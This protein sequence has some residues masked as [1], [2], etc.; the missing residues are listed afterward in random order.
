MDLDKI[1]AD[2]ANHNKIA[3]INTVIDKPS[4]FY[5]GP[6]L[7]SIN[8]T[9]KKTPVISKPKPIHPPALT[10]QTKKVQNEYSTLPRKGAFK[11]ATP[12]RFS[13]NLQVNGMHSSCI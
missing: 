12:S 6:S 8:T 4:I 13:L 11:S 7:K 1:L 5:K 3:E 10:V 9:V 2:V